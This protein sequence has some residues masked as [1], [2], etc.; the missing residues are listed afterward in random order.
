MNIRLKVTA[1]I[2][3]LC[4]ILG[5]AEILV[6]QR[7]LMPSFVELE[8]ADARTALKRINFALEMRMERLAAGA[9]DCGNWSDSYRFVQDRNA[10]YAAESATDF[11]L[12]Q[13]KVDAFA[14]LDLEGRLLL[15]KELPLADSGPAHL[16]ELSGSSLPRDF[17]W[18][19][20]L[21]PGQALKG[22]L[23]SDRGTFMLTAAPV[24]DGK[25][26][27]PVRGTILMGRLLSADEVAAIGAQ[28]QAEIAI[29]EPRA[30]LAAEGLR[31]RPETTE[32]YR[33]I[34]DIYGKHILT[35]RVD[36]PRAITERGR[37]AVT[38]ASAYLGAALLLLL[39][40][41][42][43][44]LNQV[45]LRPLDRLTRHAIA[46]GKDP[47][48]TERLNLV[49]RDEMATLAQELDRTVAR[50]AES[51]RQLVDRSFEA[52][53]AEM[54]KGVLH[55]LGN[56]MT[57]IGVRLAGLGERLRSAPLEETEQ[58]ATE[59]GTPA[60][61]SQRHAELQEFIRLG[62]KELI[63]IIRSAAA[64]VEVMSR[65]ATAVQSMLVEQRLAARNEHVIEPV[66]L[67][68]LIAQ[69]LE[70]VPDA[71]RSRLSIQADESLKS[72]GVVQVARTVLRLVLQNIIINAADAVREAHNDAG[73]LRVYAEIARDGGSEQLRL[74]C[75]DD[76]VGIA[77]ENLSRIFEPGFSTKSRDTNSGIGLH[78]CANAIGALGGRMWASSEGLGRGACIHLVLPL[79][80]RE[81]VLIAGAA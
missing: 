27:G 62:S 24:L 22:F 63:A 41:L 52:G 6:E 77:P 18:H 32:V 51:R 70:I 75:E 73:R 13:L 47:D 45:I 14:V 34:D 2:A 78:W 3:A 74:R 36:V 46:I 1:S 69:A 25:G 49:S 29:E 54:A 76:G 42:V 67:P 10:T 11:A 7:V 17:P 57:P 37:S 68:E 9:K 60:A 64:D 65:Q 48:F 53:H 61:D 19:M 8:R 71:A 72:V 43:I 30:G 20:P 33:T 35:V 58:A 12:R 26:G 16:N 81:P 23:R 5:T 40:M 66:R 79:P 80:A 15:V 56:A 50:L 59:L 38:Y 39:I 55:N 21:P 4:A 44:V 31:E 28:A